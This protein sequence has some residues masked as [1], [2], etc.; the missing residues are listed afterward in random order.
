MIRTFTK[1]LM[2]VVLFSFIGF[3]INPISMSAQIIDCN[4][5]SGGGAYF[6]NCGN[7]VGGNT[8]DLA[9]IP[10]SP[11]VLVSLSNTDCD[12]LTDLTI[13][14]SQ[15]P[16]EPDM[17]TSL[18][19]SDLGSFDISNMTLGDVIGSAVMS[20]GGGTITFNTTLTVSSIISSNQ[21]IIQSQDI[22]TGLVLGTFMITNLNPG[23]SIAASSVA[24][25]NNITSGNSQEIIFSNV[26]INPLAGTLTF[27]STVNSELVDI[28]VQNF[29]FSIV[30]V[31]CN[32]DSGGGAYLDNCGNC[33]GGN[34]GDLACIPFS[35]T[36]LVSLSNTDCDSLTDLTINVSQDPNEPD[37]ATSLFASDLGSFDISNMSSGDI[38]GSAVMSLN[39]GLNTF[40][41]TLIVSSIISTNQLI[42][43]SQNISTG[44]VLG[45][46]M[47]TNLNPG[48]SIAASSVSDNNNITS[49]N[50]QEI[51]FENVFINPD[52]GPLVFN[53]TVDSEL[54]DV[55]IQSFPF[56][57]ICLCVPNSSTDLVTSCDSYTW[58]DGLTY[59]SSNN[60]AT[61]NLLNSE[62]CD[63]IVTLNLTINIPDGCTDPTQFNYDPNALCDDGSCIPAL[64]GCLDPLAENYYAAANIDDGSC[65]YPGCID[66][67]A[68]NYDPIANVD[69]GSCIYSSASVTII[70]SCNTY[71]W[72]SVTYTASGVYT[73]FT[74][75]SNGCDSIATL[76]LTINPSTTSSTDVTECD[77]YS[78]NDTEYTSGGV[79]TFSTQ[80]S[81]GC[82]SIATLNLTINP[83]TTS[84]SSATSCDDYNWNGQTYTETGTYTFANTNSNGCDSTATLNLTINP[85]TTSTSSATSCDDYNWNGQ[86]Y[87]ASGVHTF[88]TTS[89]TGCDST[90]TLNLTINPS[91]TSTIN[92]TTCG[93]TMFNGSFYW[94]SGVYTYTTTNAAGCD[95]TVTLNLTINNAT[96]SNNGGVYCDSYDWNGTTYTSSG[97]YSFH[98]T[99]A[100]GC[101]STANLALVIF[102]STTSNASVSSCD[103]YAWNGQTYTASGVYTFA[104]TQATGCDS[105]ATLNLTINPSTVSSTNVTECDTYTWNGTTYSASG[106]YT[107]VTTNAN[108]CDSTATLNLTINPST[109][110]LITVTATNTY[111]WNSLTYTSSGVYTF[112]STNANGCDS[113]ATLDLTII[114]CVVPLNLSTTPLL[115]RATMLWDAVAGADHY[116]IRFKAA[117]ASTWLV[118][119]NLTGA[120]QIKYSLISSTVYQ[121]QIRTFCNENG[122]S[123]S[124]WSDTI[125]FNTLT[126][127][128]IPTGANTVIE[129]LTSATIQVDSVGAFA[130]EFRVKKTT[131]SWGSWV[132]HTS[133]SNV[134][135]VTGLD[136]STAYHWQARNICN[137]GGINNS[138]FT[139]YNYFTTLTPCADPN[140]L[141]TDSTG[142]FS[143]T[144]SW[145]GVG[146]DHY[147]VKYKESGYSIWESATTSTANIV[148][149]GL[150]SL[151]TYNWEV[152]SYC[153]ADGRNNSNTVLGT[154]FT[155]KNPCITP[156]GLGIS[157]ALLNKLTFTWNAEVSAN[158]YELRLR[159]VGD[160]SWLNIPFIYGTSQTKSN[161][162]L[163]TA[164]EW[165]VRSSCDATGISISDWSALQLNSTLSIC[166]PP[167][168]ASASS[169]HLTTATLNWT[170]VAGSYEYEVRFKPV[171]SSWGSWVYSTTADLFLVQSGL[172]AGTSYQWQVRTNC[173]PNG[174]NYSAWILNQ[175]VTTILPCST[176]TSLLVSS[177]TLTTAEVAIGGSY[178]TNHYS[179]IHREVGTNLWD[180]TVIVSGLINGGYSTLTFNSLQA[181]TTYEWQVS[182]ACLSDGS[183][184]SA[185]AAGPNFTTETACAIASNLTSTVSGNSVIVNWDAVAGVNHY[186]LRYRIVGES[187]WSVYSY[188][189]SNTYTKTGLNFDTQYEW[190][191]SSSC[192]ATSYN[193]SAFSPSATFVTEGC[194]EPTN[195]YSDQLATDRGTM[196]WDAALTAHHYDIRMRVA[197]GSVW[198]VNL[199]YIFATS[200]T[201]YS[202][203]DG[204]T[205]EWQLRTVCTSDTSSVSDWSATKSFTTLA[206]CNQKPFN[207][208]T[209]NITLTSATL[210]WDATS[211]AVGYIVRHKPMI[212]SWG[213]WV[214]DTVYTTT[215]NKTGLIPNTAYDW[216]IRS[217]C[218]SGNTNLSGWKSSYYITDLPCSDPTNLSVNF[219]TLNEATLY[220][221]F[222]PNVSSYTILYRVVGVA[223]WDTTTI[224]ITNLTINYGDVYYILNGLSNTSTYE[225]QLM[226]NCS[227]I[228][229]NSASAV[230]GTNFTTLTPSPMPVNITTTNID[231][232]SA[233]FNWD[234][235]SGTDHYQL[236]YALNGSS[237][238]SSIIVVPGTDSSVNISGLMS[239][240]A[241][242]WKMMAAGEANGINNSDWT[243]PLMFSTAVCVVPSGLFTNNIMID[244]VSFNWVANGA[245]Y[246]NIRYRLQGSTVWFYI[247]FVYGNSFTK[248]NL[249]AGTTYEWEIQSLCAQTMASTPPWSATQTFTIWD[250]CSIVP[251][252]TLSDNIT[253][254]SANISWY[255]TP[256][257]LG[258]IVR[259]KEN[260]ASW[261]SWVYDTLSTTSISK[262]ALT[263]N[264]AYQWQV[265]A[266]C[267][268]E[269]TNLSQWSSTEI[270]STLTP[271]VVPTNLNVP[272]YTLGISNATLNWKGTNGADHYVIVFKDV[273]ASAWDTLIVDGSTVTAVTSLPFGFIA[274]SSASGT[275]I[276]LSLNEII[277][278][279]TY[280]WQVMTA[281]SAEGI[282]S[283]AYVSGANFNTNDL[284]TLP[285][286]LFTSNIL[287]DRVT[288]NWVLTSTSVHHYNIRMK[289]AGSSVW[290]IQLNNINSNHTSKTKYNLSSGTTYEWQIQSACSSGNS[291]LSAWSSAELF[292]T[293]VT[294]DTKPSNSVVTNIELTTADLSWDAVVGAQAYEYRFKQTSASWGSWVY[295]TVTSTSVDQ[296]GLTAGVYYQWQVRTI[297]DTINTITSNWANNVQFVTLTPCADPT[298]LSV[299]SSSLTNSSATLYWIG[300]YG[301]DGYTLN[302][303]ES[304]TSIWTAVNVANSFSGSAGAY[305]ISGLS[306]NTIYEWQIATECNTG[307]NSSNY[308][309]GPLFTTTQACIIPSALNSTNVLLDRATMNWT[310]T[311]NAHHFDVRLRVQGGGWL[312]L[313]YVYNTSITKY[314]LT[315]GTIYE[316]QVRGVCSYDNSDASTWSATQSFTTLTPCSKPQNTY[317]TSIT[318]SSG[319]L[320]WD[321]VAPATSYDVRFKLYGSSWGSWQYTFG[322]TPNELLMNNLN[323]ETWYHWQVRAVCGSSANMSGWTYYNTFQILSLNRITA[324]DTELGE[325]LNIYPN[326]TRGLFNI[327]FIAEKVDNFEITI[328]DAF[329]KLVSKE[330]KQDFIGEYTKQVDLSDSPRGIYM[331][332][333][334]TQDSFVSKRIV[335]Q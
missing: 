326:P 112:V 200:Q 177:T 220:W 323:L 4:G 271:C 41:T 54:D 238:W 239:D 223:N 161:L 221:D 152:I 190:Q 1:N 218:D 268:A 213:S 170:A 234:A 76:N 263:N 302:Y 28:D 187:L 304:G 287:V 53:T 277:G 252:F 144:L 77:S 212:S 328:V 333:I 123:S 110:S 151:T 61:Q 321:V 137:A 49:G 25:N 159:A 127:C 193:S 255:A 105:T 13:N 310:T 334:M 109:T 143:A 195:L 153:E 57:I 140:A 283:S 242:V 19:A 120:S 331:L 67:S 149:T 306:A 119:P 74:A 32:G 114:I 300:T 17:A 50:S 311:A 36:V 2:S 279:T 83:S 183:N 132:Y 157:S 317:V 10:F 332:Q 20:V 294:C 244:R 37:M 47:I 75:N 98:T 273:N 39:G 158:H 210:N 247:N 191:V 59:T 65:L 256:N 124:A 173:D 295:T 33:I 169:I 31:D 27:T 289:E 285:N 189:A 82:D 52:S 194:L 329:G 90:A 240:T 258:Y 24:D 113:I 296:V 126:P 314:S 55:D 299:G 206:N 305:M 9:C 241:Y 313:F 111:T 276:S 162:T 301:A 121:W 79:Y 97:V 139:T 325:N 128:T 69:D 288:M 160:T 167:V 34:T 172:I 64:E 261:G 205:Y 202:L 164:Y 231:V 147:I 207:L 154:D 293:V 148:L 108:G 133:L 178:I 315:S 270:F 224:T 251:N 246:Y 267:N 303:R 122:T 106:V 23:V 40:S 272:G 116:E 101:D 56:S 138:G 316:W 275:N 204:T 203:T 22:N 335:L 214:Y 248:Y 21:A 84:T 184:S 284:C 319:F 309:S 215:L 136:N 100:A 290:S 198:T 208:N 254:T 107:N 81:N 71:T 58:I 102:N 6:D 188:L 235:V 327:S 134:L 307:I 85:S 48:V 171:G 8:G 265:R 94:Q 146:A 185:Y 174:N 166:T 298:S 70:E 89:A 7:C 117:S 211:N 264:T 87:T 322:V 15:D 45:T 274:T 30:C 11:T 125:N 225:W 236:R 3:L 145:V 18:F 99:N 38:I 95:S 199:I 43:E 232:F 196:N 42:I 237:N 245:P 291:I 142:I 131:G 243:A 182:S 229:T 186:T 216:R 78:W 35:P 292:T 96:S 233:T 66:P 60:S 180:T 5:D 93:G 266:Y 260:A 163:G 318:N 104:T 181:G 14:V 16:N 68:C 278:G 62:G 86:T 308:V 29:P 228:Y 262:T 330:D 281:C 156:N 168:T 175:I 192:N 12:S 179:V 259:F 165:Q 230:L 73:Y 250:D 312:N 130:Y 249:N 46:F 88:A 63:S 217:F 257:A 51:I 176:P 150:N 320:E 280:E 197:G 269:V 219:T 227:A 103:D 44:L 92:Q 226:A 91:S 26:F 297:C 209:T 286:T 80:N 282:N 155:T 115:D 135:T 118:M 253:L 201:K 324:G 129:N 72:N 141:I 222:D